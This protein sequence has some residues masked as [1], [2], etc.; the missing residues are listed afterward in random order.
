MGVGRRDC[1]LAFWD[2]VR[3]YC[4]PIFNE[5]TESKFGK[6]QISVI[7]K[8]HFSG[9]KFRKLLRQKLSL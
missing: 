7:I 5:E 8:E 4:E 9:I 1:R 2:L 3:E 6:F